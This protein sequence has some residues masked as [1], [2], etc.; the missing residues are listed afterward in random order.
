MIRH[1]EEARVRRAADSDDVNLEDGLCSP[2]WTMQ[3]E[4]VVPQAHPR[5]ERRKA[6]TLRWAFRLLAMLGATGS[7]LLALQT[8]LRPA[9][10]ARKASAEATAHLRCHVV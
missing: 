2:M 1:V 3:E 4:L 5:E 8:V 6:T 10:V 7:L 9:W